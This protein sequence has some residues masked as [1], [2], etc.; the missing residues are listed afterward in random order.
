MASKVL[1][2]VERL[3][4]AQEKRKTRGDREITASLPCA[5]NTSLM[6]LSAMQKARLA[7]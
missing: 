1:H 3:C 4:K 6:R 7:W 2:L 5:T